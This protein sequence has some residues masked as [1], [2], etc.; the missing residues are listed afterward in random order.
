[1]HY[2]VLLWLHGV[3]VSVL[4]CHARLI[5][6]PVAVCG[7][8]HHGYTPYDSAIN[9]HHINTC[10]KRLGMHVDYWHESAQML[11]VVMGRMCGSQRTDG[12]NECG[13]CVSTLGVM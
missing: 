12:I 2:A 10:A 9:I 7:A 11:C 4:W 3:F 1:M 6:R 8:L 5:M 13:I